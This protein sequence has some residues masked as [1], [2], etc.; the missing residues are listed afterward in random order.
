MLV[1]DRTREGAYCLL[2]VMGL[3]EPEPNSIQYHSLFVGKI[4]VGTTGQRNNEMTKHGR[5][6]LSAADLEKLKDVFEDPSFDNGLQWFYRAI[7][8][9]A[10][11]GADLDWLKRQARFQAGMMALGY[12]MHKIGGMLDIVAEELP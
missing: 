11:P 5:D 3:Q 2:S 7:D 1:N 6:N 4:S 10:Q 8:E 12:A 9:A